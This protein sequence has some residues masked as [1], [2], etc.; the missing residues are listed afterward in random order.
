[1]ASV[2]TEFTI[3]PASRFWSILA[4]TGITRAGCTRTT[5]Q[6]NDGYMEGRAGQNMREKMLLPSRRCSTARPAWNSKYAH[7]RLAISL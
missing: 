6:G 7:I 4:R 3:G 2:E 5:S 1:M